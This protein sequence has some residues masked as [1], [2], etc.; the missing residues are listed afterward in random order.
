M[1]ELNFPDGFTWGLAT[2]AYQIEGAA[3]E[4]GRGESVWDRFC[5]T[6]GKIAD[7]ATGDVACDHY[8]RYPEDV[9]LL[10]E[11][12]VGSYRFSISWAR[13]M[14][15]GAGSPNQRGLD[16]YD[17]LVDRLLSRGIAPTATLNH[18]DMPQALQDVGGWTSRDTV[19]RFAEYAEATFTRLGDRVA[20][21]ITHN[22]PWC[23]A[24][25]GFWRGVQAPGITGDLRAALAAAHHLHLSHGEAVRRYRDQGHSGDIGITLNLAPHRPASDSDDDQRAVQLSDGYFNRWFLDPVLRGTYPEDMVGYYTDMLGPLD[26]IRPDDIATAAAGIDFLGVNYYQP[27]MVRLTPGHD[28]GWEVIEAGAGGPVT[29]MGWEIA[30]WGLTEL[31]I[32]L[33]EDYPGTPLYITENG[34]A[35]EDSVSDDGKVHDPVRVA[36]V[37]DHFHAAHR[38]IQAGVDLRG[39]FVWSFM[40]NFEWALGYRPRFGVVYVDFATQRRIP[41][42]SARFLQEVFARNAVP[43]DPPVERPYELPTV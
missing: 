13:V 26:F 7:G 1:A 32:R 16:F 17:R 28:I 10:G 2:S 9:D 29:T 20:H 43:V 27:R 33:H 36:F 3:R 21:W 22:E 6:P 24:M 18:W 15:T 23:V 30:P 5:H 19:E 25:L 31:L 42:D 35:L 8:H 11:L 38:A 4:D 40:D 37:Y 41:K 12:G 34:A 14:P 39:Y